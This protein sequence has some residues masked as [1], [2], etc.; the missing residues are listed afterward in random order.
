MKTAWHFKTSYDVCVIG[1]GLSGLTAANCLAKLGHSV[2][3]L[4]QHFQLGGLAAWF[5]RPGGYI[6]DV[7]LHGFPIGMIKS[8]RRYWNREIADSIVQLPNVRFI[9]PQF[10]FYTTFDR[11]D[12]TDK[13]T[14]TFKVPL[15]VVEQ[16]FNH[17][18]AMNFY[19]AD[20][21]T[22]EELFEEF[23]PNRPDI[24]RLLMEPITYANGST[25]QD[26]AITYGIVFSNFMSQGVYTF[27]GGTDRLI[28]AMSMELQKN[29]VDIAK[30]TLVEKVFTEKIGG[31]PVVQG[32]Q[33]NGKNI[34]C[35]AIVSNANLKTTVLKWCDTNIL[36]DAFLEEVK[37]VRLNTSSCQVYMGLKTGETL[38][39]IGDLIFTSE[40]SH[41][42]SSELKLLNTQS[43]TFSVYYPHIRPDHE[44][45]HYT[46]VASTN[47]LWEDWVNLSEE[48]YKSAKENLKQRT[49]Q[50]L[51]K[52]VPG[53]ENKLGWIEVATPKTFSRYTLHVQ[54]ASFGTKFEGLKVS[55]DLSKHVAG[56]Y[57]SGS[58]GIIMS[59]WLGTINYGV[60]TSNKVDAYLRQLV[61]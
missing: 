46:L 10:N 51:D 20:T 18:R 25:L 16:F 43:R 27:K 4:E 42:S 17:L 35:K 30:S 54:G 1:S 14:H 21:R 48:A 26:P 47:A 38:P 49:L 7:S 40:A 29:G 44:P 34:A 22:I 41:F 9:N 11:K 23:F 37:A 13:L 3:L 58:V 60:I 45:A 32:L 28:Q 15:D 55:M 53:I 50:A 57:H 6:F 2:L 8:C 24:H 39:S 36:D 33:V 12:F 19:D 5:K 56:L 59:G 31:Q 52:I 61:A